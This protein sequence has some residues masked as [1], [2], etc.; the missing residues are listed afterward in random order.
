MTILPS[1]YLP[2]ISYFVEIIAAEGSAVVDVGEH[3]IKRTLRN[4]TEI[5]TAQGVMSLTI[6]VKRAN[7]P[8]SPMSGMEI[9]N[10]KRWQHQHWIAI[11]SAYRSSPYFEHYAPYI[12]PL[13]RAEWNHLVEFNGALMDIVL[14]LLRLEKGLYPN[15]STQYIPAEEEHLDLRAKG[16]I[17]AQ[18]GVEEYI[19]VFSDREP[20]AKNISILD[21]LFCEG[22]SALSMLKMA[23]KRQK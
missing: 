9:D 5:M 15:L 10:S 11:M 23:A 16:T 2:P 22:S 13:Y 6:P 7:S 8:R 14:R 4:R 17:E 12:E 19:Q 1:A 21:L 18:Q 20:F 3:Y